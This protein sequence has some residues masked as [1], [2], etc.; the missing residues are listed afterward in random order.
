MTPQLNYLNFDLLLER[1]EGVYIARVLGS[2]AGEATGRFELPFSELEV[3]N[4]CLKSGQPRKATRRLD[5]SQMERAKT[6]GKRLFAA[7]FDDEVLACFRRSLDQAQSR[8]A[9]LRLRLRLNAPA[10]LN[11]PWEYLYHQALNRF[12][13]LA[14]E[15]PLVRYLEL[16]ERIS[17]LTV[18][19]PL[20]ILVM[21]S[22]PFDYPQLDVDEEWMNLKNALANLEQRELVVLERLEDATL[23]ALQHRLRQGHY[24]VFHFIGH[25]DFDENTQDG[26]LLLEDENERGRHVSGQ[27]LGMLLHNHASLRLAILN[28]CEGGRTSSTDPFAGAAQSL[29]QQG[30]PAVIA[31]Q[32][33]I[34][35]EAAIT[36][37]PAFYSAI[38]DGYS[39]DAALVE[40]R[41]AIFTKG[42]DT[43]WG[44]PVLYMRAPDGRIFDFDIEREQILKPRDQEAEATEQKPR[45]EKTQPPWNWRRLVA[46]GT[47]V[48][49]M[50][51]IYFHFVY[52]KID[53]PEST[54]TPPDSEQ[55]T[56]DRPFARHK[57]QGDTF[58]DRGEYAKARGEYEQARSYRPDDEYVAAKIRECEGK[59]DAERKRFY[60]E[61][62]DEADTLFNRERF[63]SAKRKYHDALN[64]K[65]G[66]RYALNRI[67][68]CERKMVRQPGNIAGLNLYLRN[69]DEGDA[70]F[71]RGKLEAARSKYAAALKYNPDDP[72]LKR[73][74]QNC[75]E[76][77]FIP[78]GAFLMGSHEGADDEAPA[79][80]IR[81]DDFYM[82]KFEVTVEK[83]KQ[84]IEATSYRTEAEKEG[85]SW[86][87]SGNTWIQKKGIN[88]RYDAKG[89][90]IEGERT[91]HPVVHVS[92]NDA[93]AYASWAVKRLPTEAE[94]EYAARSGN[95][96]FKYSWGNVAPSGK[97]GGNIADESAKRELGDWPIWP[98]YEDGFVYTALTGTFSPN[99]LGLYDMTGNVSEWCSDWYE[100]SFYQISP[101]QDPGGPMVGTDR[102]MRGG[103]WLSLPF[104][105]R[106]T[107]RDWHAPASRLNHVGFRCVRDSR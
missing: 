60:T 57:T 79:H 16:P 93:A 61:H 55:P 74:I 78:G 30:I 7:V 103:S 43:E 82:D 90:T 95:N 88:W 35:D 6:F 86:L 65:P 58:F 84:F 97:E 4:F 1:A 99:A 9:G 5:S 15:T 21:I 107:K 91:K 94:W 89:D 49:L 34:T 25:G 56:R 54:P 42:N 17:S 18:K 26:T 12:L 20:K 32:F 85:W 2:P 29:V 70:L 83:F 102:V 69:I 73:Q 22:S 11:L 40:A 92:W 36:F 27:N 105:V 46:L 45:K 37:A 19:P 59:S 28:A 71:K 81:V 96:G 13:A 52:P 87:L 24:H 63:E 62:K 23:P 48:T 41:M 67:N 39:V 10:L 44:T 77:V 72:S 50:T 101:A 76:M 31:M 75:V 47:I 64:Q 38:A 98:G 33:E 14:I 106:S 51:I 68:D 80:Q 53:R 3:E 100:A 66:D 104:N 8:G